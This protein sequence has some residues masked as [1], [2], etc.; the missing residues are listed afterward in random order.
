MENLK[1]KHFR[2]GAIFIGLIA[3]LYL[4][5]NASY[6]TKQIQHMFKGEDPIVPAQTASSESENNP[7]PNQASIKREP[8]YIFIPSLSIK[9][10]IVESSG[11]SEKEFQDA[12]MNGVVHY[13][14][15]AEV[16]EFGNAY[17]FGHS[18]DYIF[19][20][21]NYKTV[22]ALL[23]KIEN[24]AEIYVSN[25]EG[26]T[27]KYV[28]T[29]QFVAAS[30]ATYLLDQGDGTEKILTLQTSYPLGTALKR[31]IVKAKLRE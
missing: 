6:F 8:N 13:P 24:N 10:P 31:Y 17:L 18:S 14:G 25:S 12:L 29:E 1:N 3:V 11:T 23:P 16:G 27:F 5:M 7:N 22:F 19:K 2:F 21:G 28:V 15:T 26:E 4:L 30:D 9:A 20:G